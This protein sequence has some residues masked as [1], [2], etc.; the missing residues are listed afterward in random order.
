MTQSHI[1]RNGQRAFAVLTV[2]A[3]VALIVP[4]GFSQSASCT[5]TPGGSTVSLGAAGTAS[6]GGFLPEVPQSVTILTTGNCGTLTAAAAPTYSGPGICGLPA[7]L[8]DHW[9]AASATGSTLT[10]TTLSNP[11]AGSRM[12]AI[13]I[14]SS[15]GSSTTVTVSQAG[16]STETELQR[17][18]R[19]LYQTILFRDPDGGG[20]AFWTGAGTAGLGQMA[21][22][23]LTSPEAFDTDFAVMAAFQAATGNAPS[24]AQFEAAVA[25][26]RAGTQTIPGLYTSLA[27]SSTTA[28]ASSITTLYMN[29]LNRAPGAGEIM[30]AEEAGLVAWFETL[31]GFPAAGAPVGAP[32]NEFQSTGAFHADHTNGLYIA[33]LYFVILG[34][35]YDLPGYTFWVGVANSGGPGI[36]F[37]DPAGY[38]TRLQILGPGTPGQ[39][40]LG[41]SEFTGPISCPFQ[42]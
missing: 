1:R 25:G 24:Y 16:D 2:L 32:D 12:G 19:A 34:R 9:L 30:Q 3:V 7:T 26:I 29:L 35:D 41:S 6:A 20:F 27:G 13:D 31:I 33:M 17:I 37:Q 42:P 21:D 5:L 22:D 10:F 4:R 14:S 36:L 18:V 38:A 15:T 40:F 23:F 39:G 8:P 28:T 11:N